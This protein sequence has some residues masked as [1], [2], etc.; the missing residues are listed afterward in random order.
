MREAISE[1]KRTLLLS[2]KANEPNTKTDRERQESSGFIHGPSKRSPGT[3]TLHAVCMSRET[4]GIWYEGHSGREY[5]VAAAAATPLRTAALL[6]LGSVAVGPWQRRKE[7]EVRIGSWKGSAKQ[8][9]N[10]EIEAGRA[11]GNSVSHGDLATCIALCN[12]MF[13]GLWNLTMINNGRASS[14]AR[15]MQ[16]YKWRFCLRFDF[17]HRSCLG[18]CN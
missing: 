2:S 16:L 10:M 6:F 14:S 17:R 11:V 8:G 1:K 9:R 4:H 7:I 5:V 15:L 13:L 12:R 3:R 18:T